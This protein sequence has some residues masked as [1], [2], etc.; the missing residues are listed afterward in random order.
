MTDINCKAVCDVKFSQIEGNSRT[1]SSIASSVKFSNSACI[2]RAHRHGPLF[3]VKKFMKFS[4]HETS[5]FPQLTL[6]QLVASHLRDF[7]VDYN[8]S[9]LILF[10][11]VYRQGE[12][13]IISLD[14]I[15]PIII[16]TFPLS[17]LIEVIR[18]VINI[19]LY[20][21]YMT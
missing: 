10:L 4:L 19:F 13:V 15:Y 18:G 12:R 6:T 2:Q 7:F 3:T 14:M 21:I 17:I 9:F 11:A 5:V 8:T 1:F 16:E 20:Q